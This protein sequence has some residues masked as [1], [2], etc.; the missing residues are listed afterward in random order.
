[1]TGKYSDSQRVYLTLADWLFLLNEPMVVLVKFGS[2]RKGRA[3]NLAHQN[4]GP[5]A[6]LAG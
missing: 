2:S 3:E 6:G 4:G 1:M 5:C